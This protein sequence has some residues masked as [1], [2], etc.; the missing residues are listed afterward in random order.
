VSFELPARAL[1]YYCPQ[2]HRWKIDDG[3]YEL[4][5]AASSRDL[6][7]NAAVHYTSSAVVEE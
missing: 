4:V 3:D 2:D 7:L 1:A 6:R 5:L